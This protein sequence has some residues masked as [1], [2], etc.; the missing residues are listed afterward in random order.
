MIRASLLACLLGACT[1]APCSFRNPEYASHVAAC[2]ARITKECARDAT[3]Q[4]LPDC[5]VLLE[6]KAWAREVC[7]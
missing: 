2:D 1:P 3:G 7:K 5:P 6:C 4:P